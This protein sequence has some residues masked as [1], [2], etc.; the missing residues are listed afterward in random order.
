M[1][2]S[3]L[4]DGS[5]HINVYSRGHTELGRLLT[6]PS[7]IGFE[8]PVLGYFNTAE[9]LH[10][11]L[12]TGMVDYDYAKLSGF[13]ARK[14][15]KADHKNYQHNPQFDQLMRVGWICKITQ[16]PKLYRLVMEN[17]LPLT[18]YYYYG[19]ED[20]CKI[21]LDRSGFSVKMT[22]TCDFIIGRDSMTSNNFLK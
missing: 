3:P 1:E 18:H 12:K 9:G 2:L 8:H 20:N 17:R 13:D 4:D 16:N 11:F 14:K 5:T 19:K 22:Q 21:I 6:N 10:F 7:P 15:G